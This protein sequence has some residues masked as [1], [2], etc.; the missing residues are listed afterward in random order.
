MNKQWWF[1]AIEATGLVLGHFWYNATVP[2]MVARV[3]S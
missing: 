1:R 2:S 3:L